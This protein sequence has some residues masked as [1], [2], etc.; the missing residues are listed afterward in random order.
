VG[1][2]NFSAK[3]AILLS[4][5]IWAW[6]ISRCAD[7]YYNCIPIRIGTIESPRISGTAHVILNVNNIIMFVSVFD[8]EN[9]WGRRIA[10]DD[11]GGLRGKSV[12]FRIRV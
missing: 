3:Y 8:R 5:H 1:D 9:P 6:S 4:S 10:C 12:S 11:I 7:D 2:N